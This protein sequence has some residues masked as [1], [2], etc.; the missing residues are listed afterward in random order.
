MS[1]LE[2]LD[3]GISNQY[4]HE[5]KVTRKGRNV[6]K[7][8]VVLAVDPNPPR[9]QLEMGRIVETSPGKNGFVHGFDQVRQYIL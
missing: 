7:G 4:Q 8:E 5:K 2:L 3:E 9:R 1:R 6:N